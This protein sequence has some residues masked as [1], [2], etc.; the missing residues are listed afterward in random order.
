[1]FHLLESMSVIDRSVFMVQKEVGE[2]W[3]ARPGTKDYGVLSVLLGVYARLSHLFTVGPNSFYPAPKVDS[4]VAAI[5]FS[6]HPPA[7]APFFDILRK[8]V[9]IAFQQRRK[10]LQNS[11]KVLVGGNAILLEEAFAKTGI[12]PKRRP[13][14]LSPEEFLRLGKALGTGFASSRM[15]SQ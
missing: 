8:T 15:S 2:R 4:L 10:T 5:D 1:M 3:L 6:K 9:N 11:L 14:T 12:D 7:D 13:E